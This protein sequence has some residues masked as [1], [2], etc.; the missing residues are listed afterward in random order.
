M[1]G[2]DDGTVREI[3]IRERSQLVNGEDPTAN[4]HD[5]SNVI[6]EHVFVALHL[7]SVL[8]RTEHPI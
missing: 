2:S 3:D 1:S 6:G 7:V 5:N 8:L 4:A